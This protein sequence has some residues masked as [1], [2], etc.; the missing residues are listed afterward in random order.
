MELGALVR[1]LV[2]GLELNSDAS[3]SPTYLFP[4]NSN[5]KK[6]A[7]NWTNDYLLYLDLRTGDS[8]VVDA[9]LLEMKLSEKSAVEA[10]PSA[11]AAGV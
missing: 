1:D 7:T 11:A 3:A 4:F 6:P 8:S 9:G 2:M 10:A 5:L